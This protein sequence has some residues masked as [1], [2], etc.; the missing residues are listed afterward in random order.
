MTVHPQMPSSEDDDLVAGILA[1]NEGAFQA[2]DHRFRTRIEAIARRRNLSA[3]DCK[4]LAQEALSD[5]FRAIRRGQFRG[6][7]TLGTWVHAITAA[8]IADYW[9]KNPPRQ[10]VEWTSVS[11]REMGLVETHDPASALAVRQALARLSAE[12][13]LV[14]V[15]HEQQEYTL[16]EIGRLIGRR[17]SAVSERLQQARNRFRLA[18]QGGGSEASTKR[19]KE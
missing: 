16:E 4:D 12:D 6:Q 18:L 13:Q 10:T 3:A 15:L 1:D 17:K 5:A 11:D 8:K 2:F 7:S 14:L 9:R 19:L